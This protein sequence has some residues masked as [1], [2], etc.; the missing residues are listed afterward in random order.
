MGEEPVLFKPGQ[1][2]YLAPDALIEWSPVSPAHHKGDCGAVAVAG[3]GNMALFITM[4]AEGQID[5]P[6]AGWL[7]EQPVTGERL[8]VPTSE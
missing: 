6:G 5:A 1:F 2:G 8:H 7:L 3:F 4:F